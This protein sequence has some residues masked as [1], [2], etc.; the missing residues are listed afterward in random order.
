[1]V[2]AGLWFGDSKPLMSTFLKPIYQSLL[3]LERNGVDIIVHE[4]VIEAKAFLLCTAADLPAKSLL[5]NMNQFNGEYSCGKC[6]QKGQTFKTNK[7]GCVH[8]FPFIKDE[9]VELRTKIKCIENAITARE[10]KKTLNGIKGPSLLMGLQTIRSVLIIVVF[11]EI[12]DLLKE[13]M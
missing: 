10:A 7:S 5:M 1:M 4:N 12:V 13:C 2:L 9:V 11:W 3:E 6:V 8:I